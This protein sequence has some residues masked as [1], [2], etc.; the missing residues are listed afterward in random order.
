ML[1]T[2][3]TPRL[4][5]DLM[6]FYKEQ[7]P[8]GEAFTTIR[9]CIMHNNTPVNI[10]TVMRCLEDISCLVELGRCHPVS[11]E[12]TLRYLSDISGYSVIELSDRINM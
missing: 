6:K 12:L 5:T 11:Y 4:L 2:E 1:V 10:V 7:N 3:R 8:Q 9:D